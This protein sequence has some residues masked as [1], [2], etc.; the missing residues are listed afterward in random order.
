MFFA[1]VSKGTINFY[2]LSTKMDTNYILLNRYNEFSW[3]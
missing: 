3:I 1:P 2:L